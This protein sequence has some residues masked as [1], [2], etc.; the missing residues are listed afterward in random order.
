MYHIIHLFIFFYAF[1]SS[2]VTAVQ[3]HGVKE[4]LSQS[5]NCGNS[6][7][8]TVKFNLRISIY[9]Y[10]FYGQEFTL[11]LPLPVSLLYYTC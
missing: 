3:E 10:W 11:Q 1:N 4:C 5:Q 7:L 9:L 8:V 6:V 2:S